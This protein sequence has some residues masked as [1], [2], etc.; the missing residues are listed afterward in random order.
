MIF[1]ETI[2]KGAFLIRQEK[3]KDERGFFARSFCRNEFKVHGLNPDIVQCSISFNK[4]EGTFRGMH[5][6]AAPY[7]EEKFVSCVEGAVL[8]YIIDLR[9]SSPTYGR[10]IVVELSAENGNIIYV[11]KSFAHG[12]LTL[13]DNTRLFYQMTEYYHPECA[14]G[15][16]WND[17]AF[18]LKLPFPISILSE[19]DSSYPDFETHAGSLR[20]ML[21]NSS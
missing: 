16:R 20:E 4:K 19:K 11:P 3:I 15:F 8:D 6:Q 10:W 21:T 7:Q 9:A 5:F 1:Q 2:L 14:R 13:C 12:F 18:N 17:P